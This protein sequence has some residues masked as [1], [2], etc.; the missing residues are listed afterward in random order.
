MRKSKCHACDLFVT[1]LRCFRHRPNG[2]LFFLLPRTIHSYFPPSNFEPIEPVFFFYFFVLSRRTQPP[3]EISILRDHECS[4]AN[5]RGIKENY[6]EPFR[7]ENLLSRSIHLT[8]FFRSGATS[9]VQLDACN[10][11]TFSSHFFVQ[12]ATKDWRIFAVHQ[13]L[14]LSK[15]CE[16]TWLFQ[17]R[18]LRIEIVDSVEINELRKNEN[19]HFRRGVFFDKRFSHGSRILRQVRLIHNFQLHNWDSP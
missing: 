6:I 10:V 16:E 12:S 4:P 9:I 11:H 5:W 17:L 15:W 3:Q 13:Y 19:C 18:N 7:R 14:Q 8:D 1:K 2:Y